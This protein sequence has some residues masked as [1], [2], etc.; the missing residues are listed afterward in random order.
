MGSFES[1]RT[2]LVMGVGLILTPV[3]AAAVVVAVRIATGEGDLRERGW[4][5]LH[6]CGLVQDAE[7]E[8][9]RVCVCVYVGARVCVGVCVCVCVCV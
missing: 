8:R 4:V 7:V 2:D 5:K 1:G 3:L 6:C 9:A